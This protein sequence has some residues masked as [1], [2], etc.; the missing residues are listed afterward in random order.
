MIFLG[1]GSL[2]LF[3]IPKDVVVADILVFSNI[4]AFLAVNWAPKWTK[5]LDQNFQCVPSEPNFK[6]LKNFSSNVFV[7]L[8]YLWS[9]F[10]QDRTIFGNIEAKKPPKKGHFMDAESTQETLKVF[11]FKTTNAILMILTIDIYLHKFFHLAKS[12]G[13]IHRV[14]RRKQKDSE[15]ESKNPFFVPIFTIS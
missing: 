15:N 3:D 5:T 11:N 6:I 1:P 13:V 10:Q 9:K 2:T 14:C 12:W 4:F 7:L 8:D